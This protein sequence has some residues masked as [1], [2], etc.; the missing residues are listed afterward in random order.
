[1]ST[2][3]ILFLAFLRFLIPVV[4]AGCEVD[5]GW[6]SYK[7]EKCYKIFDDLATRVN[8]DEKCSSE[9]SQSG[10]VAQVLTIRSKAE[11]E[12]LT[13]FIFQESEIFDN[14]WL[15]ANRSEL[16]DFEWQDRSKLT[17][18]NWAPGSPSNSSENNC[19]QFT[20]KLGK[21]ANVLEP[22]DGLWKDVHCNRRNLII[23]ERPPSLTLRELQDIVYGLVK[24][25]VPIGFLYTEYPNQPSPQEIWPNVIW[26]DVTSTYAGLFFRALGGESEKF[27][28]RQ[29]GN[30]PRLTS[31]SS[32]M[33]DYPKHTHY[34]DVPQ[35]GSSD[36]LHTGD[37]NGPDQL[38][39]SWLTSFTN[40]GGEVRPKNTAIRIWRRKN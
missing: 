16:S 12:F 25:P 8:A 15:G 3:L 40:T 5:D 6:V 37:D 21:R 31:V 18:T 36:W 7:N 33:V 38:I 23:C 39:N 34:V 9:V 1:M 2:K 17:Y 27:G 26:E 14:V 32:K 35:H 30:A 10:E 22:E 11:Q 4:Q 29:D 20:S 13:R 28:T 24:N 19:L